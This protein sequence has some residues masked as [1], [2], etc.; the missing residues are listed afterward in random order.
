[1]LTISDIE[2]KCVYIY[3]YTHYI[4]LLEGHV[5]GM[6]RSIMQ[7]CAWYIQLTNLNKCPCSASQ[8]AT[9]KGGLVDSHGVSAA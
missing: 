1:M 4:Y 9:R 3:V 5:F 7:G 6:E 2:I 8:D